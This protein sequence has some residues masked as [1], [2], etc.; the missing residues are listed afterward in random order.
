VKR[1]L[2]KPI[3]AW[4]DGA[5]VAPSYPTTDFR[6]GLA[7]WTPK[8]AALAKRDR[9]FT[10]NAA[11]GDKVV[12]VVADHRSARLYVFAYNG[13]TGGATARVQLRLT[14]QRDDGSLVK[15]SVGGQLYLTRDGNEWDI[16]GYDL[17]RTE[18]P[19]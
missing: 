13:K 11:L 14:E 15:V 18:A 5:F 10:T 9:N 16:F 2:T 1:A 17:S 12:A 7:S 8:A 6:A 19:A 4:I 3:D